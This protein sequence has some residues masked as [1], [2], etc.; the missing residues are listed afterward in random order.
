MKFRLQLITVPDHGP[1]EVQN[2]AELERR[3]ELRPETTGL[4]LAESKEILQALQQAVVEQQAKTYLAEHQSCAAC[5]QKLSLKGHHELKLRTVFGKLTIRS[6]RF[7]RCACQQKVG[8]QSFSPLAQLLSERVTPE[9]VYVET[10]HPKNV[11]AQGNQ[12]VSS[13]ESNNVTPTLRR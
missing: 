1:E 5:S 12:F 8:P 10:V 7:R 9:R 3:E 13:K 11:S 6:P 2:L 4:T